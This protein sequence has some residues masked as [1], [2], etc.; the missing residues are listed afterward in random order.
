[1]VNIGVLKSQLDIS[2][3]SDPVKAPT[4]LSDLFAKVLTN[5][6]PIFG[7]LFVGLLIYGGYKYMT[8]EGDAN[9]VK[10]AQ[11]VITSAIIG[12]AIVL[13]AFVIKGLI[14]KILGV[15]GF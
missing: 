6:L 7:M 14:G 12:L 9:K 8:S 11:G 1:M 2:R 3:L 10:A 4:S 13:G 15:T 5:I